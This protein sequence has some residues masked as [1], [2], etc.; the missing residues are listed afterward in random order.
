MYRRQCRLKV[1]LYQ[2]PA[3][4]ADSE[5]VD[6]DDDDS[7]DSFANDNFHHLLRPNYRLMISLTPMMMTLV[8]VAVQ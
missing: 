6:D 3:Y 5:V 1:N 2:T 4:R 8:S 7:G